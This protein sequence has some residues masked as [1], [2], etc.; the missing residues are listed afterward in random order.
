MVAPAFQ[1]PTPAALDLKRLTGPHLRHGNVIVTVELIT[2]EI[3]GQWLAELNT[4]NRNM[5]PARV[6]GHVLDMKADNWYFIG[7]TIRFSALPDGTTVLIDGQHRLAAIVKSGTAQHYIVVRGL[8]LEAQ[9]A[10]DTN[11]VRTVANTLTLRG[12]HGGRLW[13]DENTVAAI[14]RRLLLWDGADFVPAMML[15]RGAG[16][17]SGGG[18]MTKQQQ[19]DYID[20]HADEIEEATKV[21][22]KAKGG[23]FNVSITVIGAAW[24]ILARVDRLGADT[25]IVENLIQGLHVDAEKH[26]AR[27]LRRRLT[28]RDQYAPSHGVGFWLILKAWNHWREGDQIDR[29]QEPRFGWPKPSEWNIR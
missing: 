24:A 13:A 3:A 11:K 10:T 4:H 15:P 16:G 21:A 23:E 27:A 5:S 2:P 17:G 26:P 1:A 8:G 9:E 25:F 6:D 29:L 7:D 18:T 14:G 19:L 22:R 12:K 20:V 28:R